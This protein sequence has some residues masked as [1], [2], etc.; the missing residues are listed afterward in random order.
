M[1]YSLAIF[2]LSCPVLRICAGRFR[3]KS[4]IE[5]C[6]FLM[7]VKCAIWKLRTLWIGWGN[8]VEVVFQKRIFF[9]G[10][11]GAT[12]MHEMFVCNSIF[13]FLQIKLPFRMYW[14]YIGNITVT[15]DC[16]MISYSFAQFM[17]LDLLCH[18]FLVRAWLINWFNYKF[19]VLSYRNEHKKFPF[20]FM[21]WST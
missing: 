5:L 8:Y 9:Y 16:F 1:L 7:W 6:R 12:R 17:L 13:F 19:D 21:L 11:I 18:I 10:V 14:K 2:V 15:V 4:E 3:R 20:F